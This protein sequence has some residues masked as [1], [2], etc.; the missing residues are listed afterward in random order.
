MNTEQSNQ[1]PFTT[2]HAFIVGINDYQHLAPLSTA[3][4]DAEVLAEV[5]A[6][7]HG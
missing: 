2:S 7:D 6:N 5:L 4:R 3:V 1:L